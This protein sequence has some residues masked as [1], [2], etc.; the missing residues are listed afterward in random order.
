MPTIDFY[1][2]DGGAGAINSALKGFV[3]QK[4]VLPSPYNVAARNNVP[5][6]VPA[7]ESQYNPAAAIAALAF[8]ILG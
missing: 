5:T 4:N 1:T 3:G 7:A 6:A 2:G 8:K